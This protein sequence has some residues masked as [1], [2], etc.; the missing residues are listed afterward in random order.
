MG[1]LSLQTAIGVTVVLAVEH[2]GH[3]AD[4][5][6]P[7]AL[8]GKARLTRA[9]AV[10]PGLDVRLRQSDARRAAIDHTAD[11]GPV[12]LAPGGDTEQVAEA[13]VRHAVSPSI[14]THHAIKLA[15]NHQAPG[16]GRKLFPVGEPG[17]VAAPVVSSTSTMLPPRSGEPRHRW[18]GIPRC[19]FSDTAS[20]RS[21]DYGSAGR[22]KSAAAASDDF[23]P[24]TGEKYRS[25][26]LTRPST[27]AILRSLEFVLYCTH[28]KG[29][30]SLS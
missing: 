4:L 29:L 13:V 25:H 1:A 23:P 28:D 12:A 5:V 14:R 19:H 21:G 10:E 16:C 8:G 9:A 20:C 7:L 22:V 15:A 11:G 24:P 30:F 2:A 17:D 27:V 3:D 6:G 18:S 26:L